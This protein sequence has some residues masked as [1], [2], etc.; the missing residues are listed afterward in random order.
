MKG[1]TCNAN[2]QLLPPWTHKVP[3]VPAWFWFGM[4][5]IIGFMTLLQ[6]VVHAQLRA[7]HANERVLLQEVAMAKQRE[8]NLMEDTG[9]DY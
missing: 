8:T 2:V 9:C 6:A 1:S 5:K 7:L 4:I 3:P